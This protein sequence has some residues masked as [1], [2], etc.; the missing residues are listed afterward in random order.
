MNWYELNKIEL[1][2]LLKSYDKYIYNDGEEW[3]R[4]RQPICIAEFYYNEQWEK[5]NI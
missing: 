1:I 2:D 5:S 3:D 4:D